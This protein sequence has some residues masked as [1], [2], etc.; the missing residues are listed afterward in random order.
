M[1]VLTLDTHDLNPI[2]TKEL[3]GDVEKGDSVELSKRYDKYQEKLNK[4]LAG[5]K[6]A[7]RRPRDMASAIEEL[8]LDKSLS[9][10]ALAS[11]TSALQVQRDVQKDWTL[12]SP[13]S[14]GLAVFDLEIP[15]KDIYPKST[16]LVNKITRD[17]TGKGDSIRAKFITGITGSRTG[18]NALIHP[19]F[20]ESSQNPIGG[21]VLSLNRPKK[22]THTASEMNVPYHTFG[23]SDSVTWDAQDDAV[24][25]DDLRGKAITATMYALKLMDENMVLVGRGTDSAFLGA[26]AQPVIATTAPAT[27]SGQTS[28]AATTYY[29]MVTADAGGFGQSVVSAESTQIVGA[30]AVLK[31]AITPVTGAIGYR[32]YVGTA[33]GAANLKYQGT[34]TSTT[35]YVQGAAS[36]DYSNTAP[37]TTTGVAASTVGADTSAYAEGYDGIIPILLGSSGNVTALNDVFSTANPGVE[38]QA[39]FTQIWNAVLGNPDEVLMNGSDRLQLS[40]AVKAGG[41]VNNYKMEIS[42]DSIGRFIGGLVM[43]GIVNGITG[44]AV[45]LTVHPYLPQGIAPVISW[46]MPIPDTNVDRI[47]KFKNVRDYTGTQWPVIQASYDNS[48]TYRGTFLCYAP[49]WNGILTGIK[50]A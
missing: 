5:A 26:L 9:P 1:G 19:G 47:W 48:V 38:L 2:P 45:D 8:T 22:I 4:S 3:F 29:V 36:V 12:T 13:L 35:F 31:I 50:S 25:F 21:G 30:G 28:L 33:T 40:N 14:T 16:P 23:L 32:V 37:F 15:A 10:D 41:N 6:T 27:G 24:G 49:A 7:D 17:N 39:V 20:S 18:G 11:L 43:S 46:D 44:K 34:T 42:E